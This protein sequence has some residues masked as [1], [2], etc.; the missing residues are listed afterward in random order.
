MRTSLLSL[1][2]ALAALVAPPSA[3]AG[4]PAPTVVTKPRLL[5]PHGNGIFVVAFSPNGKLLASGGALDNKVRFWDPSTGLERA[6]KL[7][8]QDSVHSLAFSPDGKTLAFGGF[9]LAIHL[10]D[11]EK[12]EVRTSIVGSGRSLCF[13]PDGKT[14][15]WTGGTSIRWYDLESGKEKES[16]SWYPNFTGR[17]SVRFSPDSK[18]IAS[19]G[20]SKNHIVQIKEVATLKDPVML[21][22]TKGPGAGGLS[23]R[24][25]GKVLASSGGDGLILWEVATGKKLATL[26]PGKT[27]DRLDN[28]K[29]LTGVEFSPNGKLL[30]WA[31]QDGTATLWDVEAK[32]IVKVFQHKA[33]TPGRDVPAVMC[34]SFSPDSRSLAT[35]TSVNSYVAVW[36]TGEAK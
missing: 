18:L 26:A 11:V 5:I 30:A 13:S 17:Q 14:L 27:G 12:G 4:D 36:D 28:T 29:Y 8:T 15:A 19:G 25:D 24:P 32:R 10:G 2:L 21:E 31:S 6:T 35:G 22:G 16:I 7:A 3:T 9:N 20:S 33:I 1:I 23:F 34:L